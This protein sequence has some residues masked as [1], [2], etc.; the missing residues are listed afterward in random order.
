MAPTLALRLCIVFAVVLIVSWNTSCTAARS[1]KNMGTDVR[2]LTLFPT[3]LKQSNLREFHHG[4]GIVIYLHNM[5]TGGSTICQLAI[6]SNMRT[7]KK[8]ANNCRLGNAQMT[9]Y[10][11]HLAT[12]G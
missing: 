1:R 7:N 5:K 3:P 12:T 8:K 11:R 2:N 9:P 4:H 10:L 6:F